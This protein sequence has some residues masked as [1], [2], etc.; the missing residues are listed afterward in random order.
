MKKLLI[1][2]T[3]IASL[4]LPLLG[5]TALAAEGCKNTFAYNYD[6]NASSTPNNALCK[7]HGNGDP[8]KTTQWDGLI[9]YQI[10]IVSCNLWGLLGN[11]CFD[12]S[13]TNY[14]KSKLNPIGITFTP[15]GNGFSSYSFK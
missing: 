1:S 6:S 10:P 8:M 13:G 9:G 11:R 15:I 7:F 2:G 3:I 14:Y 5:T 4:V 12:V